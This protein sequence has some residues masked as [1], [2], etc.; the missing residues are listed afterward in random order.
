MALKLGL[1]ANFSPTF[2]V[3]SAWKDQVFPFPWSQ[4]IEEGAVEAFLLE[5]LQGKKQP[6]EP[7]GSSTPGHDEL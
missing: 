2:T 7:K 1:S 3:Y 4:Q 6:W 5:I